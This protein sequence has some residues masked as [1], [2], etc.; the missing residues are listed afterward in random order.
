MLDTICLI[1]GLIRKNI[2]TKFRVGKN[3]LLTLK[4][5]ENTEK[6]KEI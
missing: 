4:K 2:S 1:D 5:S 6:R 3:Y